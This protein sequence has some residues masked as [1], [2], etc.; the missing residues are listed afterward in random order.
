MSAA[1][2]A[3]ARLARSLA[4]CG[5]HP[6]CGSLATAPK[7]LAGQ[8][9]QQR[10][11]RQRQGGR[12]QLSASLKDEV[13]GPRSAADETQEAAPRLEPSG[14]VLRL[15][16]TA[17]AVCFDIDCTLAKND[18]LDLLAAF[19]G[20]GP[21]VAE[22]TTAAMEGTMSLEAAL[23]ARLEAIDCTPAD[24]RAFLG[25]HPAEGRL[26]PVRRSGVDAPA[27]ATS[28]LFMLC[29]SGSRAFIARHPAP[30]LSPPPAAGRAGA[31]GGAAGT[32]SSSLPHLR[33]LQG[34]LPPHR[35]R[36]GRAIQKRARESHELAAG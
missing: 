19:L 28:I 21:E 23:S 14:S 8:R 18:Q 36:P 1:N 16:Q 30:P 26:S 25:A 17:Q 2:T 33:G 4:T 6:R 31:G 24:I 9:R 12:L 35:R 7:V 11:P 27:P 20:K 13:A 34:A 22:I 32:W 10:R 15:W 5:A 3:P 29:R